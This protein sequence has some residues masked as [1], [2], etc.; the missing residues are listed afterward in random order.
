[1][2]P[3][4][5]AGDRGA[6]C[7]TG[8]AGWAVTALGKQAMQEDLPGYEFIRE[9]G[10]GGMAVVYLATQR[11]LQRPVALKLLDRT[12]A[13]YGELAQRFINEAH[14]LAGLRH[15]NIVTVYDV[16]SSD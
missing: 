1:M 7:Y 9:L 13:G 10:R 16:V 6:G 14:T 4:G 8:N 15:P 12:V 5:A 2:S 11:S 3:C